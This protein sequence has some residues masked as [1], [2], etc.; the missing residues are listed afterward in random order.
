MRKYQNV[1]SR[2]AA[3]R[4]KIANWGGFRLNGTIT[5][6]S[7]LS[8]DVAGLS[9]HMTIGTRLHLY[10]YDGLPVLSEVIGFVDGV[11]RVMPFDQ[12]EALGPG[13]TASYL[14]E[15]INWTGADR[16]AQPQFRPSGPVLSIS[17]GW[18]GRIIDPLANPLDGRGPLPVGDTLQFVRA[19]PP[20]ATQRARLGARV[21]LGVRALNLFVPCCAGQRL[22]LFAGAGVGKSTLLSMLAR[23][24]QCDVT[25][26]ALIGERGREVREFIEDG[27]GKAGLERAVIVVATSDT[28]AV[29]RREAAYTAMSIAEY[30]RDRG[31]SVLFLMDSITRF[32]TALREIGLAMG[33]LPAARGFPPSVFAEL[34]RLIERA[35]P[36]EEQ[37]ERPSGT[38]LAFFTVLVDGN[39]FTEPVADAVRS[40]LDGHVILDNHIADRGRYPAVDVLR[41]LSRLAHQCYTPEEDDMVKKARAILSTYEEMRDLVRL[42]AYRPGANAEVDLSLRLA[43]QLENM[44]QQRP[45]EQ[46]SIAEDFQKLRSVVEHDSDP[47]S[48]I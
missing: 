7:G 39:D 42:G 36:G 35:G 43:P 18:L 17:A 14:K 48:G 12:T 34:P 30:F 11:A 47:K 26:I 5:D 27:L 29:M 28:S 16:A 44:L 23:Y 41:S 21:D 13:G 46:S 15:S 19:S 1:R 2:I 31:R 10:R 37:A 24:V 32:C 25:V 38:V 40:L 6:I 20:L 4:Q 9:A 3:A 22:G 8:V 45:D 33:E